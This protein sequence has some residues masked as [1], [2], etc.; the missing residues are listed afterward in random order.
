MCGA[1]GYC[2]HFVGLWYNTLIG[3]SRDWCQGR[4]SRSNFF[5]FHALC[6][7]NRQNNSLERPPLRLAPSPLGNHEF[8]TELLISFVSLLAVEDKLEKEKFLR[9]RH[10]ITEN[11]RCEEGAVALQNGD[12][13]KF[14]QLMVAS[15]HSLR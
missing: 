3:G 2:S 9:A 7:E 13:K 1:L 4:P 8:A 5:H 12:Y 10:V 14:G 6:G 11:E 15:H